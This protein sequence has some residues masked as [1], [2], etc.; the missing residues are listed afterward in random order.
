M[1]PAACG[2]G[3]R[4]AACEDVGPGMAF[5]ARWIDVPCKMGRT[6]AFFIR[7]RMGTNQ[8]GGASPSP[9]RDCQVHSLNAGAGALAGS[10]TVTSS[11]LRG[12]LIASPTGKM[13]VDSQ[14]VGAA[15]RRPQV[16]SLPTH[17][18][19]KPSPTR[20]R[21]VHSLN[22]GAAIR[23]PRA[24]HEAPLQRNRNVYLLT[25]GA[26]ALDSPG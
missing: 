21:Q 12:R 26:V 24:L 15:I 19:G 11:P 5:A 4:D 9:A 16:G 18:R 8:A 10:P 13:N 3:E 22:A 7:R 14:N 20:D 17:G 6:R 2:Q 23:R 25:V 1:R